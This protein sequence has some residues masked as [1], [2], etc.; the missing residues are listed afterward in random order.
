MA[1][2]L[3]S[4][5]GARSF[6][7]LSIPLTFDRE[8][9]GVLERLRAEQE[10]QIRLLRELMRELGGSP[11]RSSARRLVGSILTSGVSLVLGRSF[12]LRVCVDASWT[13]ARWYGQ[14]RAYFVRLDDTGRAERCAAL[15]TTKQR[16]AQVLQTWLDNAR[17]G[18]R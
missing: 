4:E 8:L 3:R 7:R 11:R 2:A 16:H 13:V 15:A 9:R 18:A 6:Y 17:R 14:Y 5:F 1:L 12:G 10:D